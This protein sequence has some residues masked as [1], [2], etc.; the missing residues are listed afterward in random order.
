MFS[1]R[2]SYALLSCFLLAAATGL[3]G[4]AQ[5]APPLAE[6]P[7][8]PPQYRLNAGDEIRVTVFGESALS[9]THT[10]TS[11]GDIAF[12]LLGDMPVAGKSLPEVRDTLMNRLSPD[13]ITN[14]RVGVEVLNY[15]PIY[16]LGEVERAGEYKY[17]VQL[18]ALQVVAM[19]GGY[20]YRADKGRVFIRRG[21][22]T[23]ERTYRIAPGRPV[24]I[25]PGDTIRVGERY[26]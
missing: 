11:E 24:W 10:V 13:Y 16:I 12:P 20:T 17:A 9:G 18:T 6:T 7:A 25:M 22:E 14:P 19:A 2:F 26:F 1:F 4:C 3:S 15:R 21:D 5:S 8:Q 23:D